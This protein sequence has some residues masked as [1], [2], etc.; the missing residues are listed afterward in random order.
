MPSVWGATN[1]NI[2]NV[3]PPSCGTEERP[4]YTETDK[5]SLSPWMASPSAS[6]SRPQQGAQTP[7][8]PL[9]IC[10]QDAENQ[11]MELSSV[12][13]HRRSNPL[14][15]TTQRLGSDSSPC[16]I[17]L[18][19]TQ[20]YTIVSLMDSILASLAY[21]KHIPLLIILLKLSRMNSGKEDTSG[22]FHK[23]NSKPSSVP[24]SPHP[25][26]WFPNQENQENSVQRMTSPTL[27]HW[28]KTL[29]L[30]L[31]QPL[32]HMISLV[33][34]ELSQQ[35]ASLSTSSPQA[36]RLLFKTYQK[37]TALSLFTTNNGP[38]WWYTSGKRIIS[39]QT[40]ATTL[41]LPQLVEHMTCSQMQGLT[42]FV[43]SELAHYQSGSTTTFSFISLASIS[44]HTTLNAAH[45]TK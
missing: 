9:D 1:T 12:L 40:S 30:Q 3:W 11:V 32:A 38:D 6:F 37:H 21:H 10:A 17:F 2:P 42:S 4:G 43:Q 25:S 7:P 29:C 8:T 20:P 13:R 31:I 24:S 45:G 28:A 16:I 19:N 18:K 26:P 22:L 23:L 39:Q 5:G 15:L 33:P 14:T 36:W 35:C 41:D 44:T 34:G 27:T